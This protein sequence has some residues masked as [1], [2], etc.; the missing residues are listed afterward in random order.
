MENNTI[1]Y[2]PDS[3]L[4]CVCS[5]SWSPFLSRKRVDLR[6]CSCVNPP[7]PALISGFTS[8]DVAWRVVSSTR[9]RG[10]DSWSSP[11]QETA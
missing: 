7:V 8:S 4:R 9:L 5:G 10:N 3:C 6:L 2:S 1:L 11:L